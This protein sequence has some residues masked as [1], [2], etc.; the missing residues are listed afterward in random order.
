MD[1]QELLEYFIEN[2]YPRQEIVYR[3]PVS[4][5]IAE[6]WPEELQMRL[7]KAVTLPL[8]SAEGGNYWY[9]PTDRL[10]KA[11]DALSHAA[12]YENTDAMPQY[13]HDEGVIDEAFYS[14]AVEGAYSTRAK[15][16]ALIHSGKAPETRDER[17]IVNNYEALK[18]VLDHL[19]TPINE[20]VALEIARIL[21]QGTSGTDSGTGWRN[22]PVQVV[23]GRQEVVYN[24]PDAQ[25]I[26]PM[27]DDLF[28][29]IS[30]SDVHPVIKAC[31]VHICFVTIHP[32]FD[33][34]GR[35]ARALAYMILLQAGYDFF[36][37][38]PI[39]GLLM[40]ERTKYYKAIRASQ[41]PA[42]GND[43][44]YF[45]EYY[46]EMLL[47]SISGIHER[48]SKKANLEKLR[49]ETAALASAQ[50]LLNGLEWLYG[51]D[52]EAVT[53]EKWKEKFGVSFETAR[54]DL[55]WLKEHGYLTIRQQG[56]K[57]F[58]DVIKN[59]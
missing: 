47:R 41:D 2:Y 23:S 21:T 19:D 30:D 3:L 52:F 22:G 33:G 40:Q 8:R 12:R 54:K 39:S 57:V 27:L 42:N 14:S 15:A 51:K 10:L 45:M 38:V 26:R 17:M 36:R 29:Y 9:V 5:P 59:T 34:N 18:F 46:A 32:L 20:A 16:H 56:H 1:R 43:F 31:A 6:F 24:A 58:F 37:Q 11:G 50:R 44:T 49:K 28:A 7:R 25:K 35:T 13:A 53:S 4:V 48:M 55:I